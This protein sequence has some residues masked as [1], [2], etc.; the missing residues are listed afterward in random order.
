MLS[1]FVWCDDCFAFLYFMLILE[2]AVFVREMTRVGFT[3]EV[4]TVAKWVNDWSVYAV[5]RGF[6]Y[7]VLLSIIC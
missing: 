1:G 2:A 5:R 7:R 4:Y 6:P 3:H